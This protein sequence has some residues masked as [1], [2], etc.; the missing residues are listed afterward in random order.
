[1]ALEMLE[2]R[3][4]KLMT[5]FLPTTWLLNYL[6]YLSVPLRCDIWRCCGLHVHQAL[7]CFDDAVDFGNTRQGK[8]DDAAWVRRVRIPR[9]GCS[10]FR[11]PIY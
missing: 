5:F 11:K 8:F 1:M 10:L 6:D 2:P 3:N 7:V 4:N 9:I